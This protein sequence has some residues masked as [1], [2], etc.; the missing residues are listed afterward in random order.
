MNLPSFLL[1]VLSAHAGPV[2]GEATLPPLG[3]VPIGAE[4]ASPFS[5]IL[6]PGAMMVGIVYFL[7]IRP[8][9][10]EEKEHKAFLAGLQRGDKVIT[11]A[12]IHGR[13]HEVK[14]ETVVLEVADRSYLTVE[15]DVVKRKAPQ[16]AT[17]Q[18]AVSSSDAPVK[19][20]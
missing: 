6:V 20:N 11:N 18:A 13:I 17:E 16:P 9:Q 7:M 3:L 10:K 19:K 2:A 12:G 8:Q 14:A 4:A 5:S 15:R 1:S